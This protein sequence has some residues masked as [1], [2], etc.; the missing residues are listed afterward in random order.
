MADLTEQQRILVQARE[1]IKNQR[2]VYWPRAH[3]LPDNLKL[4]LRPFFQ[5]TDALDVARYVVDA[6]PNPPFRAKAAAVLGVDIDF[7]QMT[8]ITFQDTIVIADAALDPAAFTVLAFHELVHVVQYKVLG[9]DG[10][11][12]RYVGGLVGGGDYFAIP[13]ELV[14]YTAQARFMVMPAEHFSV[15][16]LVQ[17]TV[18]LGYPD[19]V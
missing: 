4:V 5:D 7:S 9:V 3:P 12:T 10:F 1:W 18:S 19:P 15:K 14:A 11:V 16:E 6:I 13:L 8:G 17:R 2:D